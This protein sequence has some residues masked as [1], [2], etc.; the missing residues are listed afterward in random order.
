MSILVVY[1]SFSSF[2]LLLDKK[3][4]L[5]GIHT[6]SQKITLPARQTLFNI[7]YA[8]SLPLDFFLE[9]KIINQKVVKLQEE[10]SKN[11]TIL[12]QIGALSEENKRLKSLLGANLSASWKFESLRVI[13]L[14][15]DEVYLQL[16]NYYP[17]INT[18]L[19]I[20]NSDESQ[21]GIRAILV[22]KI[23]KIVGSEAVGVLPSHTMSKIGVIVRSKEDGSR[24]ASGIVTGR[25]GNA[26]LD[27]ALSGENI[28]EGDLVLTSGEGKIPPELLLGYVGKI[29]QAESSPWKQAEVI[30]VKD[31]TPLDFL[32]V[33]TKL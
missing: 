12:A 13:S 26:V 14:V 15:N 28:K 9:Y 24:V 29:Y 18:P 30:L 25:G 32:A 16:T 22:G 5:V 27:Q 20:A 4:F 8:L 6:Y 11:S 21:V 2:L 3:G 19:I 1:L 31:K 10:L 33:I 23:V 17:E 7:R